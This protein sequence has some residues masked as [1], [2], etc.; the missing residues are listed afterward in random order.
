MKK[1]LPIRQTLNK[2]LPEHIKHQA[3]LAV[4]DE[5]TFDFLELGDEHSEIELERAIMNK[6]NRF[7]IENGRRVRFC[8]ESIPY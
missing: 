6:V 8:W 1:H 7:L 4:K 2:V 5:Y 3:K